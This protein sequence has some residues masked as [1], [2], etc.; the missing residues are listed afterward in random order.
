LRPNTGNFRHSLANGTITAFS[1]DSRHPT[2]KAQQAAYP[3][4]QRN[5]VL[6]W[7]LSFAARVSTST[8]GF[9]LCAKTVENLEFGSFYADPGQRN[10]GGEQG[11][12]FKSPSRVSPSGRPS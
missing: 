11:P 10:E 5:G 9:W 8:A 4:R 7:G 2:N 12:A 3:A 6:A 1:A